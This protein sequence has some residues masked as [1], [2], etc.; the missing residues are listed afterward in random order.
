MEN[1]VREILHE[2]PYSDLIKADI[3][4]MP[5]KEN[6]DVSGKYDAII[7]RGFAVD[8]IH[9][10]YPQ[11]PI[12]TIG[13]SEFDIFQTILESHIK[14]NAQ[15]IAVISFQGDFSE[16]SQIFSFLNCKVTAISNVNECDLPDIVQQLQN[17]GYDTIIGGYSAYVLN[18]V[19]KIPI[20]LIHTSRNTI[21]RAL[22][23]AV[24]T[25]EQLRSERLQTKM[26]SSLSAIMWPAI[27]PEDTSTKVQ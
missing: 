2:P 18:S 24:R 1:T 10:K 20:Y 19:S 12:I 25:I 27:W 8:R 11:Y 13:V 4:L 6:I 16:S 21:R 17:E 26:E 22:D 14:S 5:E 15:N 23:E 3:L 9:A 7:A